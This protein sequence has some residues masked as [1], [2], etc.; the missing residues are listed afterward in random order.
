MTA[1]AASYCQAYSTISA[2]NAGLYR[3]YG[4][5]L[6]FFLSPPSASCTCLFTSAMA[7]EVIVEEKDS[8]GSGKPLTGLSID[9]LSGGQWT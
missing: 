9:I 7:H 3:W 1:V 6:A 4:P 8:F 5:R 2:R